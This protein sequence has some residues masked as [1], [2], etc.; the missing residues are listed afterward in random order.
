MACF[1]GSMSRSGCPF[2]GLPRSPLRFSA[3]GPT[4]FLPPCRDMGRPVFREKLDRL[5]QPVRITHL[6]FNRGKCFFV[7]GG[8]PG[9]AGLWGGQRAPGEAPGILTSRLALRSIGVSWSYA[10]MVPRTSAWPSRIGK[11][12]YVFSSKTLCYTACCLPYSKPGPGSFRV[13]WSFQCGQPA[14]ACMNP[15]C[16]FGHLIRGVVLVGIC[17]TGGANITGPSV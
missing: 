14:R 7:L 10:D 15:G 13:C 2:F 9:Q 12:P 8:F 1:S 3:L 5:A 6:P 4:V 17:L 16:V 11:R